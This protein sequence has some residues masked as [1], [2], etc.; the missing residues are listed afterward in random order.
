MSAAVPPIFLLDLNKE[1][2][3]QREEFLSKGKNTSFEGYRVFGD[4]VKTIKAG[5]IVFEK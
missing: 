5:K 4:I 3:I 2:E 1:Y